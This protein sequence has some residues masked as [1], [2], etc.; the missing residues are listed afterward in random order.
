LTGKETEYVGDQMSC[1][2]LT[3]TSSLIWAQEAKTTFV[4]AHFLHFVALLS[5]P[6]AYVQIPLSDLLPS[7]PASSLLVL[8]TT[9]SPSIPLPI[10]LGDANLD[11][12]PDLLLITSNPSDQSR[13]PKL[14]LSEPCAKGLGGCNENG[15]GRRGFELVTKGAEPL[16]A[17][18][19]ARGVS[20]LDMDE[21]VSICTS[22]STYGLT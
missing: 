8:D 1:A 21:D 15:N 19:D 17:V 10:K 20:F 18:K 11:G 16:E 2:P 6:Q 12:F 22:D 14:L 13:T 3:P 4:A 5:I 9:Y 7:S